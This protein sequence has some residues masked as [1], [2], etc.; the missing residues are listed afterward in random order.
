MEGLETTSLESSEPVKLSGVPASLQSIG[1][2]A[3]SLE[4]VSDVNKHR[5]EAHHHLPLLPLQ[6]GAHIGCSGITLPTARCFLCATHVLSDV[7]RDIGLS[8]TLEPPAGAKKT[9]FLK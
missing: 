3:L 9:P 8:L 7:G 5:H 4:L 2:T 1:T 6:G